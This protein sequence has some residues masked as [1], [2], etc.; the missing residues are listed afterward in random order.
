M[1]PA[2]RSSFT[3]NFCFRQ[4]L[5][6]S[7]ILALALSGTAVAQQAAKKRPMT[8]NDYDSW[9]TIQAPRLSRDGR[10]VA[11]ALTPEDGD[12]EIVVRNLATGT[13]WRYGIGARQ[14]RT[15]DEEEGGA[16]APPLAPVPPP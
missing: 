6:V 15:A 13:E 16:G 14:T 5:L 8:H 1:N 11:Y 10:F 2:R 7:C 9:R 4:A 12:G 3:R